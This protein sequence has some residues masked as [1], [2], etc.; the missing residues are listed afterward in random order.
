MSVKLHRKRD[1]RNSQFREEATRTPNFKQRSLKLHKH[2]VNKEEL[3]SLA[4]QLNSPD[5]LIEKLEIMHTAI[6]QTLAE[7]FKDAITV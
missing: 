3:I 1:I 4:E 2:Q 7:K 6:D 5:C